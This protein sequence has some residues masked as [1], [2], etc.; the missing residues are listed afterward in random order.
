MV[1]TLTLF[2]LV[3]P[4]EKIH[5]SHLNLCPT[6]FPYPKALPRCFALPTCTQQKLL[7]TFHFE[8][9]N[10]IFFFCHPP[11]VSIL[12]LP[13]D[14][15]TAKSVKNN[16]PTDSEKQTAV[17]CKDNGIFCFDK[18]S[19]LSKT[20]HVSQ[21]PARFSIARYAHNGARFVCVCVPGGGGGGGGACHVTGKM[22]LLI[23]LGHIY[24]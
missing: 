5:T 18:A 8:I 2:V 14:K 10:S 6:Q 24:I 11:W 4:H 19:A 23:P 16:S 9:L 17:V 3:M 21:D 1:I 20:Y 7:S 12:C 13:A 15:A 22:F